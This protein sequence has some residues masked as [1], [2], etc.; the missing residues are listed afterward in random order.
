MAGDAG[1]S[2]MGRTPAMISTVALGGEHLG[3]TAGL[4][5]CG[6]LK[7]GRPRVGDGVLMAGQARA[8]GADVGPEQA[9]PGRRTAEG[10]RDSYAVAWRIAIR[11]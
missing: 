8:D 10:E 2:W 9:H 11:G 4:R 5:A 6:G 3:G 7:A 1:S